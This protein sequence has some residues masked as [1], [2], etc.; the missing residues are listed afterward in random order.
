MQVVRVGPHPH[1]RRLDRP[2]PRLLRIEPGRVCLDVLD[3]R[4]TPALRREIEDRLARPLDEAAFR[5]RRE[6]YFLGRRVRFSA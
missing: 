5:I 2:E 6:V 1:H 4:C 3:E